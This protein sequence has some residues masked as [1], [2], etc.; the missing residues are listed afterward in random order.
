[1]PHRQPE[2]I[3]P[4]SFP[5]YNPQVQPW[6]RHPA[7]Q[8]AIA[9]RPI[10]TEYMR[11]WTGVARRFVGRFHQKPAPEFEIANGVSFLVAQVCA[12]RRRLLAKL[13]IEDPIVPILRCQRKDI[14]PSPQPDTGD[15]CNEQQS[16]EQSSKR[17]AGVLKSHTDNACD[18]S[19]S[20]F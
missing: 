5:H 11:D 3:A 19:H 16:L 7:N 13:A 15:P 4:D 2:N 9:A 10:A 1:M 20:K 14:R 8:F 6:N 17:T 12:E 18:Y